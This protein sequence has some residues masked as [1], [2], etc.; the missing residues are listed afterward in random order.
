[1]TRSPPRPPAVHSVSTRSLGG[2]ALRLSGCLAACLSGYLAGCL[3][4]RG[5]RRRGADDPAPERGEVALLGLESAMDQIPAHPLGH[6]EIK[7][8]DQPAG[9]KVI[10]DIGADAHRDAEPVDGGLQRLAVELKLRPARVDARDACGLQPYRPILGGMRDAQQAWRLQI[11]WALQG[12]G[13]P[14]R[15]Q[16]HTL[17]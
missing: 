11:G 15:A 3:A 10:V 2:M 9:G 14:R 6:A 16:R 12:R 13:S 17:G 8:G 7:W 1:P 5:R 4:A